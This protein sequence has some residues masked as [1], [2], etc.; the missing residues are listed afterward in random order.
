MT[1]LVILFALPLLAQAA[2]DPGGGWQ[3]SGELHG[4]HY[5]VDSLFAR[6]PGDDYPAD[7]RKPQPPGADDR[8]PPLAP[9]NPAPP[10][11]PASNGPPVAGD[12]DY[13]GTLLVV[14]GEYR[15]LSEER[16]RRYLQLSLDAM[17]YRNQNDYDEQSG[18]IALYHEA[19][20][21]DRGWQLG[22]G[23]LHDRRGGRAY[24][25][26]LDISGYL[27]RSFTQGSRTSLALELERSAYQ[28][29]YDN[30][31]DKL[32][33]LDTELT[34]S[35]KFLAP[36]GG[37]RPGYFTIHGF[38][39]QSDK[40][41]G[42]YDDNHL[43]FGLSYQREFAGGGSLSIGVSEQLTRYP[44]RDGRPFGDQLSDERD[45]TLTL[46]Y[47]HPLGDLGALQLFA[48][49]LDREA[50]NSDYDVQQLGL[51]LGLSRDF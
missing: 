28:L 13:H 50:N 21:K 3:W 6:V 11:A 42:V 38:V 43:G 30:P 40:G 41:R 18:R 9:A 33:G 12:Q 26:A 36:F 5:R 39:G 1:R 31:G 17:D 34:L 23:L 24:Y 46:G 35:H 48:E 15:L 51:F 4:F 27:Y 25:N 22:A 45:R 20:G 32:D 7:Q 19:W 2:P 29:D 16:R 47:R 49:Y 10:P 44:L 37:K 8:L 14:N